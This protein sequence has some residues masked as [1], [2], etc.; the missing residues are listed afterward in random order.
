MKLIHFDCVFAMKVY[1]QSLK[2]EISTKYW[3]HVHQRAVDRHCY[4]E[5]FHRKCTKQPEMTPWVTSYE[6]FNFYKHLKNEIL[7]EYVIVSGKSSKRR[8]QN[9]PFYALKWPMC[10]FKKQGYHI[11]VIIKTGFCVEFVRKCIYCGFLNTVRYVHDIIVRYN[12][13]QKHPG[14]WSQ[15]VT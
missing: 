4:L 6:S 12:G 13:S 15:V 5:V 10:D 8:S 14:S 2:K 9:K 7:F 11:I 3:A 1:C